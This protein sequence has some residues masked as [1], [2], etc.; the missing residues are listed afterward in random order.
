M[1][2]A[3]QPSQP[4]ATPSPPVNY[5][6]GTAGAKRNAAKAKQSGKNKDSNRNESQSAAIQARDLGDPARDSCW[7]PCCMPS[8][9]AAILAA[10]SNPLAQVAKLA[11]APA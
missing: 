4:A 8:G 5:A 6:T 9:C 2:D 1:A 10:Q 11:D 7:A 3:L